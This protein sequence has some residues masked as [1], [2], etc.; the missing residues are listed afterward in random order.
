MT[1]SLLPAPYRNIADRFPAEPRRLTGLSAGRVLAV[2]ALAGVLVLTVLPVSAGQSGDDGGVVTIEVDDSVA[3]QD[4]PAAGAE[5]A[6]KAAPAEIG[7]AAEQPAEA[8]KEGNETDADGSNALNTAQNENEDYGPEAEAKEPNLPKIP[9][10]GSF[11]HAI[12]IEVPAFRGL[13]PNLTLSYSSSGGFRYDRR[14]KGLIAVGWRLAGLPTIER[15]SPGRGTPRF[16]GT[17]IYMLDGEELIAC[18]AAQSTNASCSGGGTYS[19]RVESYQRI[20]RNWSANTWA[21]RTRDGTAYLL[22]SL[23]AIKGNGATDN[24]ATKYR[25]LVRKVTDT[26][27]NFLYYKYSCGTLPNCRP[28]S[29][30]Y[31]NKGQPADGSGSPVAKITFHYEDRAKPDGTPTHLTYATGESLAVANKRL[32]TIKVQADGV[33]RHAYKLTYDYGTATGLSRLKSVQ[34]FG[35]NATFDANNVVTGGQALP[36]T[37]NNY[38]GGMVSFSGSNTEIFSNFVPRGLTWS[39]ILDIN[40]DGK[41]DV[42]RYGPP[43]SDPFGT[44]RLFVNISGEGKEVIAKVDFSDYTE[45]TCYPYVTEECFPDGFGD[46]YCITHDDGEERFFVADFNGDGLEDI[47]VVRGKS[48]DF[49]IVKLIRTG[50]YKYKAIEG[51]HFK[52]SHGYMGNY[53]TLRHLFVGNFDNDGRTDVGFFGQKGAVVFSGGDSHKVNYWIEADSS[54]YLK[55]WF[56]SVGD[57]N[58]D[59][60]TDLFV[61]R[62]NRIDVWRSD[63]TKFILNPHRPGEEDRYYHHPVARDFVSE[64][65]VADING[66][67]LSDIVEVYAPNSLLNIHVTLSN[68]NGFVNSDP[69][70]TNIARAGIRMGTGDVDGD[71]RADLFLGTGPWGDTRLW[72]SNGHT[73]EATD[74]I[75]PNFNTLADVNGD[76]RLDVIYSA[77]VGAVYLAK[78]PVPNLL[79]AVTNPQGGKTTVDYAPSTRWL[80]PENSPDDLLPFVMQTV[81]SVKRDD[82]RGQ[83]ATTSYAYTGGKWDAVERMFYGFKTVE[84]TLPC[85][86]VIA[87]QSCPVITGTYRQDIA[88]H[89][90]L[91]LITYNDGSTTLREIDQVYAVEKK[92]PPFSAKLT[93]TYRRDHYG[94]TVRETRIQ[95]YYDVYGNLTQIREHGKNGVSGDERTTLY[96]RTQNTGKYIVSK[97]KRIKVHKGLGNS[98]T[99][100]RHDQ[101]YYDENDSIDDAPTK[102]DLTKV[103]RQI[104]AGT[105][106]WTNTK[107]GYD[108]YGNLT[109]TTDPEGA[110]TE[111]VYNWLKLYPVTERL[112]NYFAPAND[113]RFVIKTTW[114]TKCGAEATITDINGKVT[115]RAYDNLCRITRENRPDGDYTKTSYLNFGDPAQQRIEE[116]TPPVAGISGDIW[117]RKYFDGLGRTYK[118]LARGPAAGDEIR[119]NTEYDKRG[120]VKSKSAPYYQ[121]DAIYATTFAYDALDRETRR[122]HPDGHFVTTSYLNSSIGL[123]RTEIKDEMNHVTRIHHDAYDRVI[124]TSRFLGSTAVNTDRSYNELDQLTRVTDDAGN[125]WDYKVNALGWRTRVDDPDLGRWHYEHDK[126]GR[127]TKQTDARGKITTFAYDKQGRLTR[128]VSNTGFAPGKAPGRFVVDNIYDEARSGYANTGRLTTATHTMYDPNGAVLT[129]RGLTRRLDYRAAGQIRRERWYI[130]TDGVRQITTGYDAANRMVWRRYPDSDL[131]RYAYDRAG[132]LKSVGA[133][134]SKNN[135]VKSLIYNARGQVTKA[136]YQNSAVTTNLYNVKRGFVTEIKTQSNNASGQLVTRQRLRYSYDKKGRITQILSNRNIENWTYSYDSLDRLKKATNAGDGSL[137]QS[138]QYDTIG[139]MTYN[140]KVGSYTYDANHPH[141]V[142]K[143][144]PHSFTYDA[145]GNMLT[146]RGHIY[147]FNGDN[148]PFKIVTPNDTL[149]F[150]YGPDGGRFRKDAGGQV[151]KYLG[152]D[153]EIKPDGKLVKYV[154]EDVK[155]VAVPKTGGGYNHQGNY[156]LHRGHLKSVR[157]VTKWDGT[158]IRASHFRPYGERLDHWVSTSPGADEAKGFI[159]ERHDEE[160]G[161]DLPQCKVLHGPDYRPDS[162]PRTRWTRS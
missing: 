126:T 61:H 45:F 55:A 66:D 80:I 37:S 150:D 90:L 95:R 86:N 96:E 118:E 141:A 50:K 125:R 82:G 76:G 133:D 154:H 100:R 57:I 26:H 70:V 142:K 115:T 121:G 116:A 41:K 11:G 146:G 119:I 74:F 63:G 29:I 113:N 159:G 38:S 104:N 64:L 153:V 35:T 78:S 143:A 28:Q 77:N 124:R 148:K 131:V 54:E 94:S 109:W 43:T 27:G 17:D 16:D 5:D 93:N 46:E 137:T 84:A 67:G 2:M 158:Q 97:I 139:N 9:S 88:S 114:N 52:Y 6:E 128:K 68:G 34:K 120:N 30:N 122:T 112:P 157:I 83:V 58:G 106:I 91:D 19:T 31:F 20:N 98:G 69:V 36:P 51:G 161:P 103:W 107:Y 53:Y 7:D 79:S 44:C 145:N 22:E 156:W 136:T 72:M 130:G 4:D 71:G 65:S 59:G 101:F 39:L 33:L 10:N 162:P 110:R 8:V 25:W 138:F 18:S 117:S 102:G 99:L 144:G 1:T 3:P 149:I 108:G 60:L 160:T 15:A 140:S 155:R 12:P 75:V 21:V 111:Y 14:S 132:L 40:G 81:T 152:G 13:Q 129:D 105:W 123:Y 135:L 23:A 89:G 92:D 62:D 87:A 85:V 56:L 42:A 147:A 134:P 127:V 73:L 49:T 24:I 151:T 32:I 47:G 48:G